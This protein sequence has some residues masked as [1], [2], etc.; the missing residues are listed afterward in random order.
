MP[1]GFL[2]GGDLGIR[3]LESCYRLYD[4]QSY[5]LDQLGE[6]SIYGIL[7][8]KNTLQGY[9]IS[10]PSRVGKINVILHAINTQGCVKKR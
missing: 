2:F 1:Q 9:T 5:A 3:T 7:Q 10:N 6:I 8:E 4:F